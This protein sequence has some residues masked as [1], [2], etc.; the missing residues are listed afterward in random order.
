MSAAIPSDRV[1]VYCIGA[2][3]A[4]GVATLSGLLVLEEGVVRPGG[5]VSEYP[6]FDRLPFRP[7]GRWVVGGC[8]LEGVPLL[9]TFEGQVRS[10]IIPAADREFVRTGLAAAE[11]RIDSVAGLAAAMAEPGGDP[12]TLTGKAAVAELRALLRAFKAQHEIDRL[13]VLSVCSTEPQTPEGEALRDLDRWDELDTALAR[14]ARGLPWG[15]LYAAAA[16]LEDCAFVNFTPN[17]GTDLPALSDLAAR[18]KLP[19]AGKDGKTGETLLK[20]VLAPMFH[21]RDLDVLAW[22]GYNLLGNNDGRA[23]SDPRARAAKISSKDRQL[24]ALLPR[25]TSL[26][27]GV[28]IDYVPSLGDFKTAWDF[29]HFRGFLGASMSFQFVWSGCDTALAAPLVLELLRFTD[30]AWRRGETGHL[31]HLDA[32]FK[33]PT[34]STEHDFRCQMARLRAHFAPEAVDLGEPAHHCVDHGS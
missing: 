6:P 31:S 9:E 16:L 24:R 29:V 33:S 1:G 8:D 34:G 11:Q 14:P 2:R 17:L 32:Y 7:W 23:L 28:G 3:G 4:I 10:G 12:G 5:M 20:S 19:H 26:H 27:T 22:Q 13:I 30:L 15:P 18:R 21:E 25:S